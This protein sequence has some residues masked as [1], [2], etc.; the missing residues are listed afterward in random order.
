[1]FGLLTWPCYGTW[2]AGPGRGCVDPGRALLDEPPPEPDERVSLS[3][4]QSL[5]WPAVEL[6]APEQRIIMVD[7]LRIAEIR[8][9]EVLVAVAAIDHVH[10]LFRV[11]DDR[12]IARLVQLTKGALSRA[13]AVG[14]S[15][16]PSVSA[17]PSA[18]TLPFRKW[19]TRQY[20]FRSTRDNVVAAVMRRRLADHEATDA[21][22]VADWPDTIG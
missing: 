7:L 20:S 18:K 14:S 15:D 4:R 13:L 22:V 8:R 3:R 16:T 6:A 9:F 19:W 1:M 17:K 21:L 11:A 12:D 10:I 2:L 5:K